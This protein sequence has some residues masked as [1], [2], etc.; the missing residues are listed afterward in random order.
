MGGERGIQKQKKK[1]E[2]MKSS[3]LTWIS[4]V[5]RKNQKRIS[6][7][8]YNY[9][10]INQTT[11]REYCDTYIYMHMYVRTYIYIYIYIYI[12][13]YVRTY[14]HTYVYMHAWFTYLT[15]SY[16]IRMLR[17][18]RNTEQSVPAFITVT[19]CRFCVR[20]QWIYLSSVCWGKIYICWIG[21]VDVWAKFFHTISF[22]IITSICSTSK[23]T[24]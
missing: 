17:Y 1:R 4:V 12:Y 15:G 6:R 3:S 2:D 16:I 14:V 9:I 11:K 19:G 7:Y 8:I 13:T 22:M 18:S 5:L 20:G 23:T 24:R 21:H 10:Y